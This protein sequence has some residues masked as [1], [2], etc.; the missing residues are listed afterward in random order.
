M[1]PKCKAGSM[2]QMGISSSK[3]QCTVCGYTEYRAGSGSSV[4]STISANRQKRYENS[5]DF[6]TA[7]RNTNDALRGMDQSG[8][9]AYSSGS[10]KKEKGGTSVLGVIAVMIILWILFYS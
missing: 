10:Q 4:S 6:N 5:N 1:C 7:L 2:R 8:G 9:N 3:W